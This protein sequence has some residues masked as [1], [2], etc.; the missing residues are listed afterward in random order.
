MQRAE[1]A[2]YNRRCR[3]RAAPSP[4]PASFPPADARLP[5]RPER[6]PS[7]VSPEALAAARD[8]IRDA[9]TVVVKVGSSSLT[10]PAGVLD[11]ERLTSLTQALAARRLAGS[12]IVLV[13]SGAIAAGIVPLGYTTRPRDLATQQ[14]AASVGQGLSSP[15]TRGPS[16]RTGSPW[17]R[18]C[19]RSTT[20]SGG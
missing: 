19:S 6:L 20:S 4:A 11:V 10:T 16:G 17:G 3:R 7:G 2:A 13:S 18:C 5:A 14:A 1:T 9:Q 12:K 8:R 15:P